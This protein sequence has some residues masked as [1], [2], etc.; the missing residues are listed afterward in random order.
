[1]CEAN[2]YL[3]RDGQE[4]LVMESVDLVEPE[5]NHSQYRLVSIFGEQKIIRGR[6]TRMHLVD[7]K[8]LFEKM[9]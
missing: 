8:I 7:H 2:A 3:I 6:I 1:M 4:E 9:E 5:E